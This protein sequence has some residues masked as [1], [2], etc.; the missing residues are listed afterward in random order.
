MAVA[1][2]QKPGGGVWSLAVARDGY[3]MAATW[4]VP[5]ALTSEKSKGRADRMRIMW[6]IGVNGADPQRVTDTTNM[7]TS[8]NNLW[9][10]S[11][12]IGSRHYSRE[13]FYPI[14]K[15]NVWYVTCQV[16]AGNA[17]GWSSAVPSVTYHFAK[18][19]KP[20]IGAYA[21]DADTGIISTT[22]TTNAGADKYERWDT[23]YYWR[24]RN[25]TTG[26]W[27][28]NVHTSSR[29][30]SIS[31]SV[32][33]AGLQSLGAGHVE[34]VCKARARGYAGPS[35]WVERR[36]YL[37]FPN[38]P[39]IRRIDAPTGI[40]GTV[41]AYINVNRTTQHPVT[42]VQLQALVDTEY[43]T[44]EEASAAASEWDVVGAPDD[45]ACTALAV[46]VADVRPTTAGRHSWL[47]VR[48]VDVIDNLLVAYSAP[49]EL[50]TLYRPAYS[51]VGDTVT[52]VDGHPGA[53]GESAVMLL[54]WDDDGSDGTE[55]SWSN[56]Q[57]TW[58]STDEPDTFNVLYD[59]GPLTYGTDSYGHSATITI[60]GL[61]E[62]QTTYVKARRYSE[63]AD[64][65]TY[66][67][68]SETY[69]VT[70]AIV[71]ASVVLDAP[72]YVAE[73]RDLTL[74]WT[75]D[76]GAAQDAWSVL[77]GAGTVVASGQTALGTCTIEAERL[78]SLATG[79]TLTL[80]VMVSMG[81]AWV[82]SAEKTVTIV[83]APTL[84]ATTAA[85]LAAQPMAISAT[86]DAAD[87]ALTVIVTSNGASGCG[88]AGMQVQAAGDVVWSG[89]VT[90]E[91]TSG[92][93]TVTLPD[94]L[95]F[96]DG[97]TYV[98]TVTATS[99]S[100]GLSSDTVTATTAVAW[101]HQAPDPEDCATVTTDPVAKTATIALTAPTG[102]V[103]TDRYDIYRLTQD[104][105][106]LIG[107]GYPL[108]ATVT[109]DYAPYGDGMELA[110]RV[111]LRTADG[112]VQ[113]TD[114][115]YELGGSAI[116]VDWAGQSVELPYNI[117][118]SDGYAKSVDVHEYLDGSTDAF[119]NQGIRRTA[120]LSTDVMRLTD[121]DT[122]A[123][124]LEL[125]H[126]VGPA[127]VRTPTGAAYE[128]DVQVESVAPTSQLAAVSV[129]ATEVRL[130]SAYMLPPY[131]VEE[132]D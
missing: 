2:T 111:A 49:K 97:A 121:A 57:D 103:T 39:V 116:R 6:S 119:F 104:G 5:D 78:A 9:L 1:I 19:R 28:K 23:E 42:K 64:E 74:T 124:V 20:S 56:E 58:R 15:V 120:K 59:D 108:D 98:A 10:T 68:Y 17:K 30:T 52:I 109:D 13:S 16:R 95:A 123:A 29:S 36:Y 22:I 81:G 54:G 87:A 128:A 45:G 65:T 85:T 25:T 31:L 44:V 63:G 96:A 91:W 102:S 33:V 99:P 32:N 47:R 46:N 100:T 70:P 71:P 48:A 69:M 61:D 12:D 24:V 66:G 21:V 93:A 37:A 106:Q 40:T 127:F 4:K 118:I 14:T 89:V 43:S 132:D 84:T 83:E 11:F 67:P 129:N 3:K 82:A 113:W 130:T 34:C 86:C 125:A 112:D 79:G 77:D 88:P 92:A 55:L 80:S 72:A 131:D 7:A 51:A 53:D 38:A 18:P 94:G 122:I 8:A 117:A 115:G 76:G 35:E 101:S 75:Y 110:Y 27:L 105:A 73:G 62:G 126:H 60:K 114:A 41:V 90:P 26:Q 50:T 107:E